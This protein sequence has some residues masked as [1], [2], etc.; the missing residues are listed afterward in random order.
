MAKLGTVTFSGSSGKPYTLDYYNL[1]STWSEVAGVYVVSRYDATANKIHAIYVGET[2]NLKNRFANHHKQSCFDKNNANTLCWIDE[3]NS[4][5][6]FAT[7]A[8]LL[9]GLKPPCND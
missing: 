4:Q 2:D 6:R 1:A 8:D 7:E 5:S 3:T 9:G